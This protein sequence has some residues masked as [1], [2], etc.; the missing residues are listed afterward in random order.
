VPHL[1]GRYR[2]LTRDD[3]HGCGLFR[4][5]TLSPGLTSW[6]AAFERFRGVETGVRLPLLLGR[7][8]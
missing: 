8:R 7:K 6:R 2:G 4:F 5:V 3:L 1:A